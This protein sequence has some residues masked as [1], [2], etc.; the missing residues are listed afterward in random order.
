[1]SRD[2]P[3]FPIKSE[4]S[5][6]LRQNKGEDCQETGPLLQDGWANRAQTYKSSTLIMLLLKYVKKAFSPG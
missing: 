6:Y 2:T 3:K 5:V 4:I 1:M